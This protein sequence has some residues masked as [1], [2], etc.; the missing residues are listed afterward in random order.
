LKEDAAM[1]VDTCARL[2]IRAMQQRKRE[3][4]MTARARL[5]RYLKL[6][7]PG[8][9]EKMALAAVKEDVRP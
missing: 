4:V 2:I 5:G 3:I 1:S 6:L 8:F 7:V 9:V